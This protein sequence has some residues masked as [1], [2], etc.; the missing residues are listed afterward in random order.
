MKKKNMIIAT[1]S[2]TIKHQKIVK[3]YDNLIFQLK[4]DTNRRKKNYERSN[5]LV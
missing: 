4:C 1:F 3:I 2:L 5:S